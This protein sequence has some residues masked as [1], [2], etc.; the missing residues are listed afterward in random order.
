MIKNISLIGILFTIQFS[1]HS[2]TKIHQ[3]KKAIKSMC[4]CFQVGFNF[5]E[6]FAYS[7]DSTYKPS[8]EKH[9]GALEWVQLVEDSED[10]ISM[11]HLLIVGENTIVKH[12][13]QDWEYQ[14]QQLYV[15]NHDNKWD[16]VQKTPEEVKGQWTQRVFQVDDS[17]RYE[18]SASWIHVDGKSFWENTTSA[19]LPRREYTQRSDYN[20][21]LRGNRH[22]IT[23]EGWIHDQDNKKIIR[24]EA[25]ED[26]ILA[27]EKGY[28]T[29]VK[30]ADSKCKAA[31]DWWKE[32][33]DFWAKVRLNW[34]EIYG[35]GKHLELAS[36]VKGKKLYEV[37]FDMNTDS[38]IK[39]VKRAMNEFVL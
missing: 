11:Q 9:S 37:L 25:Q 10:K 35:K 22:E 34:K 26:I 2:Q 8:K 31:Q 23:N 30:V 33:K 29:Y 1:V 18:G 17:P 6:T 14:N 7:E 32:N 36:M 19:P 38:E 20:V 21:T 4:G 28:N 12:W 24:S 16:F 15:Y 3:D 27:E 5:S 39:K 13:R